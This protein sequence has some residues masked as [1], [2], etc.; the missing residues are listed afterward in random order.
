M[1]IDAICDEVWSQSLTILKSKGWEI[2]I[3]E[4]PNICQTFIP[5][6]ERDTIKHVSSLIIGTLLQKF[7][8]LD[9]AKEILEN[10][11]NVDN[12]YIRYESKL[13]LGRIYS[14][15]GE[16]SN[17][18]QELK[19]IID[20]PSTFNKGR[21]DIAQSVFWRLGFLSFFE[22]KADDSIN[23]F[24]EHKEKIASSHSSKMANNL[25]FSNINKLLSNSF[26]IKKIH[27]LNIIG[28]ENYIFDGLAVEGDVKF[29]SIAKS[30]IVPMMLEGVILLEL[31][32]KLN[33]L[34]QLLMCRKLL[35]YEHLNVRS[36][37]ISEAIFCIKKMQHGRFSL[38]IIM[39]SIE[40]DE[41]H[42]IFLM[43]EFGKNL[44][45]LA[46]SQANE[47]F[48]EFIG[49]NTYG[50][51]FISENSLS[52]KGTHLT[53]DS[54]LFIWDGAQKKGLELRKFLNESLDFK[55]YTLD[56]EIFLGL[57]ASEKINRISSFVKFAVVH[58]TKNTG[59]YIGHLKA[60]LGKN[61]IVELTNGNKYI[62][63]LG[64]SSIEIPPKQISTIFTKI[65]EQLK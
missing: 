59:F 62:E 18:Y 27:D 40:N 48:L 28:F 47:R 4:I 54:V 19:S 33:A 45:E 42:K 9:I 15:M 23:L 11:K 20:K 61:R 60:I 12:S 6:N 31:Q 22:K 3:K 53:K 50:K 63:N 65:R 1:N 34:V 52:K 39:H 64:L 41:V 58:H 13:V 37:G 8:K 25:T 2:C 24:S 43:N 21:S 7:G 56:D 30:I 38:K 49:Y 10:L 51:L 35:K 26:D 46:I 36:E 17:A 44:V 57:T 14:Q 16:F 29:V 5:D 55:V 32:Q